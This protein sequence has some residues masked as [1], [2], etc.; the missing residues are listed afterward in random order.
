MVSQTG[1]LTAL[2]QALRPEGSI[3]QKAPG[4]GRGHGGFG[5][6]ICKFSRG[7]Q[8]RARWVGSAISDTHDQTN[9]NCAKLHKP[10]L[11]Q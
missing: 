8:T 3:F 9:G 10:L 4:I 6:C 5:V 1:N 7:A 2:M 11:V